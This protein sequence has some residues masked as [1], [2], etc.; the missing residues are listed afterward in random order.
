MLL[1][2]AAAVHLY[3]ATKARK[4][5]E[6]AVVLVMAVYGPLVF[7]LSTVV[8]AI[9]LSISSA[10]FAGRQFQTIAAADDVFEGPAIVL[11][12]VLGFSGVIAL[13]YWLVKG[14]LDAMRIGL[15]SRF[16]GVIGIAIGPALVLGFGSLILPIW[17]AALGFL[18][19]RLWPTRL[20]PA[21][22]EGRAVALPSSRERLREAFDEGIDTTPN[23][24]VE[25]VG[26][27]VRPPEAAGGSAGE[28][29]ARRKRKR[30]Q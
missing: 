12:T 30:R 6:S 2:I 5:D 7:A 13:A 11:S 9:A 4:P 28:S 18:F 15:L 3:R 25:A 22:T 10:D 16:M 20:P 27:G 23:G 8:R 14:G 1:M 17:L 26:P 29:V 24:E 19:L 21:W